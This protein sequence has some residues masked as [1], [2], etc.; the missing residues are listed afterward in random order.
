[1]IL[2]FDP[3]RM[4]SRPT[5]ETEAL[6]QW[7]DFITDGNK[8]HILAVQEAIESLDPMSRTCVEAVFYEGLS[9]SKLG[10][11]LKVSKPHAWRLS[12]R[13]MA[14]LQRKLLVNHSINLRYKMFDYWEEAAEAIVDEWSTLCAP[15][16]AN[17]GHLKS[18]AKTL[19]K[20]VRDR[21]EIPRLDIIDIAHHAIGELK[22]QK[23]WD[24]DEMVDL[25]VRKQRDYG[26]GNIM[27]FGHVGVAIRICDKLARL[28]TLV[29]SGAKPS[30]ESLIDTWMDLVGYAVI[31]EMLFMETFELELKDE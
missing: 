5:N 22:S 31:S 8:E 17:Y 13:A 16:H 27:A 18:Y 12:R 4:A 14:E 1:M 6:L 29:T 19:A 23:Q 20:A 30:N 24:K 7:G 3:D 9:Y 11:R 26:H 21:N 15:A 10:A 25:L 2:G 28:D